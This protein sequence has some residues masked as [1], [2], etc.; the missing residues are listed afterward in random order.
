MKRYCGWWLSVIFVVP[1]FG[2]ASPCPVGLTVPNGGDCPVECFADGIGEVVAD[3]NCIGD[4]SFLCIS[5]PGPFI[6][7]ESGC[8]VREPGV[9]F[10]TSHPLTDTDFAELADPWRPCTEDERRTAF[11]SA[12]LCEP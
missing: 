3:H 2:C 10:L 12:V 5:T 6:S 1:L 8:A 9:L 7:G 11:G 4:V